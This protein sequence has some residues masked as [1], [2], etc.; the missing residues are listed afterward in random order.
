MNV[1]ETSS[2]R[3]VPS[4]DRSKSPKPK[5]DS[6]ESVTDLFRGAVERHIALSS[7]FVSRYNAKA[8]GSRPSAPTSKHVAESGDC[9][10][11][12]VSVKERARRSTQAC[13][14]PA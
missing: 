7:V 13:Q 6:V 1:K 3:G 2:Q 5:N 10:E 9:S 12:A 11:H 14:L 8:G 4:I